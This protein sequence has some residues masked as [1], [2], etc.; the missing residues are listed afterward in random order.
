M[1]L[2]F[3]LL[4]TKSRARLVTFT[5]IDGITRLLQSDDSLLPGDNWVRVEWPLVLGKP[6]LVLDLPAPDN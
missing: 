5:D 4:L 2:S 1:Q 6:I 3:F